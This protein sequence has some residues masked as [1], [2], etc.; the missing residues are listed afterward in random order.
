MGRESS[1]VYEYTYTYS[2]LRVSPYHHRSIDTFSCAPFFQT[3]HH[4]PYCQFL[5]LF[6]FFFPFLNT[7]T[8]TQTRQ[9]AKPLFPSTARRQ[10]AKY[11][12]ERASFLLSKKVLRSIDRTWSRPRYTPTH[13]QMDNILGPFSPLCDG[14]MQHIH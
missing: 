9:E 8:H 4:H 1:Q 11:G 2:P 10:R 13:T 6:S 7:Y 14:D 3:T 12:S 5:G